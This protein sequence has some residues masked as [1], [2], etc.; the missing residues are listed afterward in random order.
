[1]IKD[2][3]GWL[4]KWL[5]CVI[6]GMLLICGVYILPTNNMKENVARSSAV[7]DYEGIYPQLANGYKYMQLDNY[8][9]SIMLGAAIFNE[10]AGIKEKAVNNYHIDC[11]EL[12]PELAL[13][14][15][16]NEAPYNFYSVSYSRYWHGYLVPLKTALLFLDYADIRVLNFIIQSILLFYIV[17]LFYKAKIEAYL[18]SFGIMILVLNPL[19]IALSLQYSSI[20]YI[21]LLASIALLKTYTKK[22]G[23]N[24]SVMKNIVFFTGVMSSFFDLLT[25][26]L[27]PLGV[28]MVLYIILCSKDKEHSGFLGEAVKLLVVWGFGYFG[29][30]M[31]KWV[32]GS[33]MLHA[34]LFAD[35]VG[36]I[37][38]RVSSPSQISEGNRL[39]A[40]LQNLKVLLKWPF[41]I[42]FFV[43]SIYYIYKMKKDTMTKIPVIHVSK[44]IRGNY[45]TVVILGVLA[46]LPL[47]WLWLLANHS[48]THYWFT[49]REL[50]ISVFSI[51]SLLIMFKEKCGMETNENEENTK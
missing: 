1:M 42:L 9:D 29:M 7:F 16:A 11:S 10:N 49:Y 48:I 26:P 2:G 39:N 38:L 3:A 14:N 6:V 23:I 24:Y 41:V 17:T 36:Q 21:M 15:Y 20:Y 34:N 13:T 25:Y 27:V 33:L 18:S 40:I 43:W 5:L 22:G 4:T 47:L 46:L 50:A 8:T 37:G 45:K 44:Y 19:A 31:G 12:S 32:I 35:A 28:V 30:W 51:C